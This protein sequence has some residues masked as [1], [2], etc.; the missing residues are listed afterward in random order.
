[1]DNR[2]FFKNI[3]IGAGPAG[4]Q[5]A[6]YYEKYNIEYVV[7]EKESIAG[8]FFDNFP[9]SGKLISINKKYTGSDDKEFNLRHDW[10]SLLNDDDFS[11]KNY[12]DDY[13]PSSKALVEYLNDFAKKF[14]LKIKYNVKVITVE[15]GEKSEN[16]EINYKIITENNE[17]Y[18][19]NKLVVAV[20]LSKP[21]RPNFNSA[22]DSIKHY[23]DFPQGYFLDKDNL[24]KYEN[25][26]IIII[27]GGNATFELANMLNNVCSTIGIIGSV[28]SNM[29][30][31]S[32]YT[33][34]L[35][36]VY[37]P[38]LDTFYLKSLNF[39]V[40]DFNTE[41]F[42]NKKI[43][44][45]EEN[46]VKKYTIV[47][48][49]DESEEAFGN[50][51]NYDEI[52]YCT[53]WQ[54]NNSIFKFDVNLTKNKK[55]P[56]INGKYESSNNPNLFFIGSLMHSLDCKKSSGGF[57]HGFRYLIKSF[58]NMNYNIPNKVLEFKLNGNL[59]CYNDLAKHIMYRVNNAS[60]LYQMYGIMSDIFYFDETTKCIKYVEDVTVFNI[61]KYTSSNNIIKF[62][63]LVLKYR[64]NYEYDLRKMGTF[65]YVD[66][67]FLH[68]EISIH[69]GNNPVDN[70]IFSD[71][72]V[73][74][75]SADSYIK[76]LSRCLYSCFLV[77]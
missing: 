48:A 39:I 6:Y 27:G 57:I 9:H 20:G 40:C 62:N 75:F 24:K 56:E 36:S 11:F 63:K 13:Y 69:N 12:S 29:A 72:L 32:H 60:S 46:G 77:F 34:D 45:K 43:I 7:L 33:G 41:K 16:N 68:I 51:K 49:S 74:D 31:S 38:F 65:D 18:E 28:K 58:V 8:S 23:G 52:I 42:P 53:G 71:Q 54:F 26:K 47:E 73:A 66:P 5:L 64:N 30:I 10:N 35:R 55:Y 22:P 2:H 67:I 4:I 50:I 25:K 19:C 70:I 61:K 59:D 17:I 3:I 37:M 15:K 14:E 76:K 1:M 21:Y 44:E